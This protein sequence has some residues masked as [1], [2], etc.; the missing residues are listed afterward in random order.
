MT[1]LN[2]SNE[3]NRLNTLIAEKL[4]LNKDRIEDEESIELNTWRTVARQLVERDFPELFEAEVT[5][6]MRRYLPR[7]AGC[8]GSDLSHEQT[9]QVRHMV[10]NL[11]D[12]TLKALQMAL[13]CGESDLGNAIYG[14]STS[15]RRGSS[16]SSS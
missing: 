5:A 15:S 1:R 14:P 11:R 7:A 3:N 6:L 12:A 13:M 10:E 8:S 4:Q 16:G 9:L 2:G